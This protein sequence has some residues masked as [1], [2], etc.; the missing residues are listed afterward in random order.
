MQGLGWLD[1]EPFLFAHQLSEQTVLGVWLGLTF[2]PS[3]R[4]SYIA[5]WCD[6]DPYDRHTFYFNPS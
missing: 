4:D 5:R 6:C 3:N 2:P 1:L